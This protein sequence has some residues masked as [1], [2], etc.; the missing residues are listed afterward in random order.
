MVFAS[1]TSYT[2]QRFEMDFRRL[3]YPYLAILDISVVAGNTRNPEWSRCRKLPGSTCGQGR[4]CTDGKERKRLAK[5][6]GIRR[7]DEE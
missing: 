3:Y 5:I 4:K 7:V 1:Q 2:I 6:F